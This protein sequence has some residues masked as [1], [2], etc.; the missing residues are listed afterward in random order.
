MRL[1][2]Q[3]NVYTLHLNTYTT[4]ALKAFANKAFRIYNQPKQL[5]I[6]IFF[7]LQSLQFYII[8]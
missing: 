2:I 7:D 4:Y 1:Y 8:N 5:Y 3:E 6:F